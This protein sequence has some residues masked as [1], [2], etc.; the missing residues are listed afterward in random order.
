[1]SHHLLDLA[2]ILQ[3]LKRL[4]GQAAVDLEPIDQRGHG[5]ESVRLH[6]LVQFVRCRLVQDYRVVSFV[7][8]CFSGV[9]SDE[10]QR[11]REDV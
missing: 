6:V 9:S 10:A 1:M 11:R 7:L 3:I 5:D 2:L 8:D 4:P